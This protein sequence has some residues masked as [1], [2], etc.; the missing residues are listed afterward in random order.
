[1]AGSRQPENH[2]RR[3]PA[4]APLEAWQRLAEV[5][6]WP[7]WAPHITLVTVSPPG[8][9]GPTSSGALHIKRLGRTSLPPPL[10][11]PQRTGAGAER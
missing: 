2:G 3:D 4:A 9:L 11:W 10:V 5:E 6:R 1:M 8:A 7:E